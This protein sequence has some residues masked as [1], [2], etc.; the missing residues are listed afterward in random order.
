MVNINFSE[1][2]YDE[3]VSHVDDAVT[4]LR[5][6]AYYEGYQQ[7]KFD[8]QM[9]ALMLTTAQAQRDA[10]VEQAKRD[11]AELTGGW[12]FLHSKFIVNREKRAV[13]ALIYGRATQKLQ[14]KGIAKCAPT[15]CFNAHIGKAIALRRAL[16]LDV[17]STYLNAPQPT[18]VR[19]G[20]VVK[21]ALENGGVEVKPVIS[22]HDGRLNAHLP[23]RAIQFPS[24]Y[25][26][27]IDDSR[28]GNA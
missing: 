4:A 14:R 24:N 11:V 21:V 2:S 3:L 25:A 20:D 13:T 19:V 23:G 28:G 17:P 26:T 5:R 15:D 1:M 9:D 16:G 8:E 7:G 6:R 12:T 18:E 22:L 27:I 10:I